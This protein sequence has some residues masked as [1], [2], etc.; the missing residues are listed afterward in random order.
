MTSA[1][2]SPLPPAA[3]PPAPVRTVLIVDDSRVSRLVA[4]QYIL[5]FHADWRVEEAGTGEEALAKAP[6]LRPDLVLMDV[7]MPGMGGLA[8]AEQ[9]RRMLPHASISLLT[10]NVQDATRARA[11]E[12]GVGFM[13]K[14]ITPER[15]GRLVATVGA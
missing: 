5:S 1:S 12:I 2:S 13:E 4:R 3:T 6:D 14:P 8:C 9:L 11:Q 10:A 15:I 7:N